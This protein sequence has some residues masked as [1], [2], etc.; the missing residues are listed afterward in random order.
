MCNVI[1]NINIV[2]VKSGEGNKG[3]IILTQQDPPWIRCSF[4]VASK[5]GHEVF[6]ILF[7]SIIHYSFIILNGIVR[8][9]FCTAVAL[10]P[11]LRV[12]AAASCVSLFFHRT[13]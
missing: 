2:L 6:F 13:L 4:M 10:L 3:G 8:F 12:A 11:H 7:E 9:S 5:L 1:Y